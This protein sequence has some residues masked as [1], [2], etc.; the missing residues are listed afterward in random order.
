MEVLFFGTGVPLHG[1]RHLLDAIDQCEGVRLTLIGGAADDRKRARAM[2]SH[3][4]CVADEFVPEAQLRRYLD[5]THLVAGVF[6]T[7][8]KA[9]R[10]VPLK[11]M[12]GLSAGR[13]VITG[14][15]P[16]IT[17]TLRDGVECVTVPMGDD[18][19]LAMELQRLAD[20]PE[21]LRAL[22]AA[23]G[24]AYRREFS[25]TRVGERLRSVCAGLAEGGVFTAPADHV[26]LQPELNELEACTR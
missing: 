6:G 10:V 9:R 3:K 8:D 14:R 21:Q 7:S 13:P 19:A 5:R 12:L 25:L 1:L 26:D 16:A 23:G 2:P 11:V 4:V 17:S 15:T 20:A 24:C 22:A 18:K